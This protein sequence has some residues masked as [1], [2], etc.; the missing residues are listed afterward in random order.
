MFAVLA[1]LFASIMELLFGVAIFAIVYHIFFADW[2]RN[3][4]LERQRRADAATS[5]EKIAQ[6]KLISDDPRD[7]ENFITTYAAGISTEMVTKLV[8]RIEVLKTDNVIDADTIL[9]RRIDALGPQEEL[10]VEEAYPVN[11]R[12]I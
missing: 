7:I 4:K 8:E 1:A 3:K 6:L 2:F 11:K 10:E 5:T 9:K 12:T